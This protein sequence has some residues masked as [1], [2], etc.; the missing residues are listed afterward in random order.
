MNEDS[1]ITYF[2]CECGSEQHT[3][4]VNS[5][6]KWDDFFPPELY[7][8]VQLNARVGFLHRC[9]LALRYIFG[10]ECRFGHWDVT[11]I[12]E[13]NI[14]KLTILLHQHRVKLLKHKDFKKGKK[15]DRPRTK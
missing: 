3:F 4:R 8:S 7:I 9:Y 2:E 14:D 13:K 5:E 15:Y 11:T 1:E 6:N 12:K 10:Y